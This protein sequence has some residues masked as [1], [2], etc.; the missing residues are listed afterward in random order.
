[1]PAKK[2]TAEVKPE[3]NGVDLAELKRCQEDIA[4]F[5][6]K[7]V[8]VNGPN[9]D[10]GKLRLTEFQIAVL[11][12]RS[13]SG[14]STHI[15]TLGMRAGRNML[16]A[17]EAPVVELGARIMALEKAELGVVGTMGR[18]PNSLNKIKG[19]TVPNLDKVAPTMPNTNFM[20]KMLSNSPN[21]KIN[22]TVDVEVKR[23]KMKGKVVSFSNNTGA[24]SIKVNGKT[25]IFYRHGDIFKKTK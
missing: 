1:M 3:L 24:V 23:K 9:G 2:P 8:R 4:Y 12:A 5:I 10:V 6:D 15:Q 7:Y 22:Q 13:N 20:V 25:E 21:V 14:K 17:L 16:I 11:A 18:L 19:Y